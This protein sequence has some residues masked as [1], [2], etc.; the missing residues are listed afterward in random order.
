MPNPAFFFILNTET[1]NLKLPS[2]ATRL[3]PTQQHDTSNGMIRWFTMLLVLAS[4]A[5]GDATSQSISLE[6]AISTALANNRD[7]AVQELELNGR[8]LATEQARYR[9]AFNLSP[10][11]AVGVQSSAETARYGLVGA[12]RLEYGP[13]LIAGVR[14]EDSNFDNAER[15]RSGIAHVELR[16]PLFRD[17]GKLVNQE[18]IKR[19][20]SRL[21]A[22]QRLLELRK[23]DLVVQVVE[24]S[25]GLLRLRRLMEDEQ[26]TVERYDRLLRLTRAR[27]KQGR[28]TRVDSLRVAFLKG[29]SEARMASTLE[30]IRS[31]QSDFANL[32]GG[33]PDALWMPEET[34]DMRWARP[35]RADAVRL[36]LLNRLDFAQA[37]QDAD[38][39][40]R[41]LRVAEKRLQ[42]SLAMVARYE[43]F[44]QGRDW[45]DAWAFDEDGWSVAL[46]SSSDFFLRDE[47]IGVQ[48]AGLDKQTAAI[49]VDDV[50]AMIQRQVD[51][52]LSAHRRAEVEQEIAESN[53]ELA[54]QRAVLARRLFEKGRVDNTAA[55]D[56]EIELLDAQ[57]K[58]LN[59]RAEA[60][61]AGYRLLRTMGLL[62][63]SPEELKPPAVRKS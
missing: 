43:R 35:E 27:E 52:A 21:V 42:P 39:A 57:T 40:A 12:Q 53:L 11:A 5:H 37:L 61:I 50:N 15:R 55:T 20:D 34:E 60:V 10:V 51:Q 14:A 7:I 19:A 4:V 41:G 6:D 16:Q 59:A 3:H 8:V 1:R 25:Q 47:R 58:L 46:A 38:D 26:R 2:P 29:Q 54:T 48:Q 31:L 18:S 62:L 49:R 56:A 22:G 13:E 36:A 63:D 9:F 28:A 44:G 23:T 45:S 30:Q 32:L 17:W 24:A 33:S